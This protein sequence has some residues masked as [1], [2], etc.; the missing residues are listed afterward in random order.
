MTKN[1]FRPLLSMLALLSITGCTGI[2][3]GV[4][5]VEGVDAQRYLGKWHEIARLDQSFERGL[6]K[7][8]AD[9][10]LRD[11]GGI[12]VMN[13]GFSA[14]E[15]KW[16]EA[17]G[18][19]YFVGD[20]TIG[21]L[22]VAFFGPFYGSYIIADLDKTHYSYALVCG[23][24]HSYLWILARTPTLPDATL[25]HLLQ[26]ASEFGFATNKLIFVK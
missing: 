12:K 1:I 13:R 19:A 5:P 2:P 23:P 9:Y 7:I 15:N 26:K 25:N 18:K 17:E 22:K 16:K 3:K 11:D 10:S 20:K 14:S 21:H 6:S 4:K 24:D 8:T